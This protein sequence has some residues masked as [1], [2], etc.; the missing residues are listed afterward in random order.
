[1][2]AHQDAERS[3]ILAERGRLR[4]RLLEDLD[5]AAHDYTATLEVDAQDGA[6]L[7]QL[8]DIHLRRGEFARAVELCEQRVAGARDPSLCAALLVEAATLCED[9]L[10]D[11]ASATDFYRRALELDP[12]SRPAAGALARLYRRRGRWL[13][14]V[15]VYEQA[16]IQAPS[17]AESAMW[18]HRAAP[19]FRDRLRGGARR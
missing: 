5:G 6:V 12:T 11:E 2:A 18:L 19:G 9:R 15:G 17:Y 16:A 7:M 4:E 14:L 1:A 10:T 8:S 13:D 3:A